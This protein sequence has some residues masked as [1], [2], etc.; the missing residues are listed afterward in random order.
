MSDCERWHVLQPKSALTPATAKITLESCASSS[1]SRCLSSATCAW[2]ATSCVPAQ[3]GKQVSQVG[4][5]GAVMI[6]QITHLMAELTH[7]FIHSL[8]MAEIA[9]ES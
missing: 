5:K 3:M 7:E 8:T 1:P 9:H 6:C 4:R 2:R